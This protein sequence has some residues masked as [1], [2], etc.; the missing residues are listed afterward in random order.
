AIGQKHEGYQQGNSFGAPYRY[1]ENTWYDDMEW[2]AAELYIALRKPSY[3]AD[4][5][6][7]AGIIGPTSWMQYETSDMG[8]QMSRHYERYPF[9][10]I[11]HYSL[12]QIADIK[13]KR[14]IAS[15]YRDGIEIISARAK[16]NP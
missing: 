5:K 13:T 8:D 15:Y 7:Y 14:E 10:N 9:T 2:A 16:T 6:R 3:L 11:G 12:Y 1:N 4:A